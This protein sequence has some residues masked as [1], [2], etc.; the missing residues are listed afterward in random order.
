MQ[1]ATPRYRIYAAAF[2]AAIAT[3]FV[4]PNIG[5]ASQGSDRVAA[6]YVCP[7]IC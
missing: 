1:R 7:P 3:V 2:M 6:H 4:V 5:A